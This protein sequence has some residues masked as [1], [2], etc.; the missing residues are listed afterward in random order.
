[1]LRLPAKLEQE[2]YPAPTSVEELSQIV[3]KLNKKV[4]AVDHK[5]EE[6]KNRNICKKAVANGIINT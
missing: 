6:S 3:E 2:Y 1:M 5:I 4:Q